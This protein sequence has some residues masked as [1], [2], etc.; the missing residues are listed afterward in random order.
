MGSYVL[1]EDLRQRPSAGRSVVWRDLAECAIHCGLEQGVV[2]LHEEVCWLS[3]SVLFAPAAREEAAQEVVADGVDAHTEQQERCA[4]VP[5]RGELVAGGEL[6]IVHRVLLLESPCN[7]VLG[8]EREAH[9]DNAFN[10]PWR[11][12]GGGGA[13]VGGKGVEVGDHRLAVAHGEQSRI[14]DAVDVGDLVEEVVAE[15][16]LASSG[17]PVRVDVHAQLA[18]LGLGERDHFGGASTCP[19]DRRDA[20]AKAPRSDV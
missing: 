5:P 4:V 19:V 8:A 7:E 16:L 18:L 10:R 1:G 17:E 12:S 6:A 9:D 20:G 3:V 2:T 15:R 11:A 13:G 14:E